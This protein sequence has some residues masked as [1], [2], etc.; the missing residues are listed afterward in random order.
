VVE[1]AE[2]ERNGQYMIAGIPPGEWRVGFDAGP[3]YQLQFYDGVS[4]FGAA[5]A[6]G[7]TAGAAVTAVDATMLAPSL[8]PVVPPSLHLSPPAGSTA[9]GGAGTPGG[10][11]ATGAK[12]PPSIS[13]ASSKIALHG[14]AIGV[15][16]LCRAAPCSGSVVLRA[17]VTIAGRSHGRHFHRA[18][19]ITLGRG[20]FVL[21]SGGRDSV[22]AEL[23]K[24]GARLLGHMRKHRL[25]A[26]LSITVQGGSPLTRPVKITLAR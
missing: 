16:V 7:V 22:L 8:E 3:G 19:T 12:V 14:R 18:E 9:S 24:S 17:R 5:R 15:E 4:E 23:T 21:A 25:T 1:C 20:S 26:T 2:S 13:L 6:V 10:T 11:G